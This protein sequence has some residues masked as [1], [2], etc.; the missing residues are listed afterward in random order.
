MLYIN[1]VLSCDLQSIFQ[2]D[3]EKHNKRMHGN[4]KKENLQ[5]KKSTR[6]RTVAEAELTVMLLAV[7][8][9]FLLTTPAVFVV[10][11][12]GM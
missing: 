3:I 7:T 2:H 6:E 12:I 8:V 11:V 9:S 4:S 5:I 1:Y 10:L